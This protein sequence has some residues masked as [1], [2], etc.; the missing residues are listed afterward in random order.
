MAKSRVLCIVYYGDF[1]YNEKVIESLQEKYEVA[2]VNYQNLPADTEAFD[3]M[4]QLGL[5]PD[6]EEGIRFFR[7]HGRRFAS[8]TIVVSAHKCPV[9]ASRIRGPGIE[10]FERDPRNTDPAPLVAVVDKVLLTRAAV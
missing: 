9:V 10:Y 5:S 3:L 6:A 4:I 1:L 7:Q 2:G 8:R